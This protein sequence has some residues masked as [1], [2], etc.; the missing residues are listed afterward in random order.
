M[1]N[2]IDIKK[3]FFAP[4]RYMT[5]RETGSLVNACDLHPDDHRAP[6]GC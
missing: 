2:D 4:L 1:S 3:I 5:I 6:D